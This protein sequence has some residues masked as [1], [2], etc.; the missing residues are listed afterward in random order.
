MMKKYRYFTI[1][2]LFSFVASTQAASVIKGTSGDR[3]GKGTIGI[4]CGDLQDPLNSMTP[5]THYS[6]ASYSNSNYSNKEMKLENFEFCLRE[7]LM[8]VYEERATNK[9]KVQ[10][11]IMYRVFEEYHDLIKH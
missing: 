11:Q 3:D 7:M 10:I 9:E 5:L 8:K 6:N 4:V 2:A 1:I